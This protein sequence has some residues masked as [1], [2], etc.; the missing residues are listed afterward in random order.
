MYPILEKTF[1]LTSMSDVSN[2]HDDYVKKIDAV[3]YRKDNTSSTFCIKGVHST[4]EPIVA[5]REYNEPTKER[6]SECDVAVLLRRRAEGEELPR[7]LVMYYYGDFDILRGYN[8]ARMD[9]VLDCIE[10]GRCRRE[11]PHVGNRGETYYNAE[12]DVAWLQNPI[13]VCFED[14]YDALYQNKVREWKRKLSDLSL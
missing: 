6:R 10:E 11:Q 13:A 5:L 9:D 7:I 2:T 4:Y 12:V 14:V 3:G 1:A 8:I